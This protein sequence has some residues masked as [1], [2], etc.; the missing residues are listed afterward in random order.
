[1]VTQLPDNQRIV[2]TGI[3]L[4]APN[5]NS[6]DEY[7]R[8]LLEGRSGVQEYEI[9]YFG[10][11]VAG[12]CDFDPLR[13]Q[14]RKEIRRGTR[15]GSVGIYCAREAVADAGIDWENVD[16]ATVGIYIGVTE[17]GNVETEN[18]IYLIKGFDYD[19]QYWSHHHN[20]RTVANNPAGEISL[21]MGITGPHYTLGAACAAGNAGLIQG[22]QML[23]LGECD[24]ALAGGVSESI[25][26]FGIFASFN[27]QGALARHEDPAKASRPF[28]ADR[29]GIVVAEGGCVCTLERLTDAKARGAKIYCEIVGHAMNSDA[30]DFVLPNPDRQAECIRLALKRARLNPEDVDIVSTHATGTTHGD[31]QEATALRQV[32][33]GNGNTLLNNTKSF[34]GH[35]M[36]A[37]GVLEL[38]GNLPALRDGLCHATI[39]FDRVDPDCELPGLVT[40]QPRELGQVNTIL[41]NSFGMLGIN[42][43]VIVRRV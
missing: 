43:V 28:D 35:A 5:G 29:T 36:G 30:V 42:S 1:M 41:N 4:T 22:M 23:R 26:T 8:S 33:D 25:H 31:I 15:A 32:F 21:N 10:K 17:H 39:N 38:V 3:G 34:I 11:T 37:A 13:Y 27:S 14:K 12:I 2:I 40:N 7:R 18:E 20:P 16:R 6:L 19:T 9:R 24:L